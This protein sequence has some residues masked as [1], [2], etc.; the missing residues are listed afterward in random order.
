MLIGIDGNEANIEKRVGVNVYAFDLLWSIWQAQK[1]SPKKHSLI[2]YLKNRPLADM[3]PETSY[4]KYRIL[5]GRG[6]WILTRLTPLLW[7]SSDK[8]DVFFSPSHYLPPLAPMPLVSSIMDLGYLEFSGQFRKYDYWQ[9]RLWS[10]ISIFVSKAVI[11]ISN[12]TKAD[13]VRRYP[14]AS[15]KIYVTHLGYDRNKF[16]AEISK[17][18]VRLIK[19][20]YSI[21]GDYLL[22]LGTLKPSKNIG[23]LLESFSRILKEAEIKLV[24]AGKKG[25]LYS[26]IFEKVKELGL[27]KEVIFTDYIVEGDKP[28]LIAG[29]KAF[30]IPSFWEGFG[31]DVL[32]AMACGVPVVVSKIGSLPEVVGEAG[33][34]VDPDSVESIAAGIKK[35]LSM[36]KVEYNKQVKKGLAQAAKF[37]WEKTAKKTLEIIENAKR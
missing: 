23:R 4:F 35:V 21:V 29:A 11:A 10:A 30:V 24:I 8:P 9:L 16:R 22:F 27:T 37:S 19:E 18:D 36:S 5:P 14:F 15:K 13:I 34:F 1:K 32:P 3:P 28:A 7:L 31:L 17:E 2:V 6:V 12:S 33:I 20:K 25:W 26:P